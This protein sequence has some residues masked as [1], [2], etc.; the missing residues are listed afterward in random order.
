M[1]KTDRFFNHMMPYEIVVV[2]Y[3]SP[4]SLT[5]IILSGS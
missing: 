4:V 2:R 5:A 1:L 3:A